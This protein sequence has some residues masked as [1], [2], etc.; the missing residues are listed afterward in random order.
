MTTQVSSPKITYQILVVEDDPQMSALLQLMVTRMG[1]KPVEATKATE[2]LDHIQKGHA[3]LMLLDLQMPGAS[4]V[5]LLRTLR[6]RNLRVPT[7]VVS[8]FISADAAKLL[9]ELGVL[10]LVAK[11]FE[12]ERII[13]EIQKVLQK[14]DSTP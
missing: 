4:G 5:D 13:G 9:S 2:A 3:D 14:Y 8:G 10:S 6:R 12:Q 7:I 11:P 1:H